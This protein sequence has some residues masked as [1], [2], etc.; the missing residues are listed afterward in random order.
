[1]NIYLLWLLVRV[2]LH[3]AYDGA[4]FML[5]PDDGSLE[6]ILGH[7]IRAPNRS[8]RPAGNCGSSPTARVRI[9]GSRG[10]DPT[11]LDPK[12][13]RMTREYFIYLFIRLKYIIYNNIVM[14]SW[15]WLLFNVICYMRVIGGMPLP[16]RT[17]N[18]T[19]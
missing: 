13:P 3:R 2:D 6:K 17:E 14:M 16:F 19:N 9:G 8:D 18:P 7:L 11:R 4:A 1:M 12:N 5:V 15:I 10:D